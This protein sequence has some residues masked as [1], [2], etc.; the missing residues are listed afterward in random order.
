MP[1]QHL[2]LIRHAQGFHNLC[3][4]NHQLRDPRL[5]ELGEQQ[6]RELSS[7][8][9][10]LASF[11]LIVASPIKRTIY[12]A[13][14]TFATLLKQR[15]DLRIIALPDLQ[16]TS[17]L[18]CDTG[19]D[20]PD[21]I[22]EF[23]HHPVDFS[24]LSDGWNE[25]TTAPFAPVPS[26]ILARAKRA[27]EWLRTREEKEIAVVTHGG[28]L[29]FFTGDWTDHSIF[30]G[31]GWANCEYRVYSLDNSTAAKTADAA[32]VETGESRLRRKGHEIPLTEAEQRNLADAATSAWVANGF[33]KTTLPTNG[34]TDGGELERVVSQEGAKQVSA[35]A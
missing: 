1:P 35:Q 16:E 15:P 27:R 4:A 5:T 9:P 29:H 17:A 13:L 21:L 28:F 24:L 19:S 14:Y 31:T 26:L 8:I 22:E 2:T 12:T 30:T 3:E 10:N 6:C 18:P 32:L 34:T 7:K 25:K 23:K 33:L 20:I 11:D